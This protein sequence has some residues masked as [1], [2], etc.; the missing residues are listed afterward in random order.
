V[1]RSGYRVLGHERQYAPSAVVR[2]EQRGST[3]PFARGFFLVRTAAGFTSLADPY[4]CPLHFDRR[5]GTFRCT[6]GSGR[7]DRAGRR[8]AGRG[9]RGSVTLARYPTR[10][11]TYG[12]VLVGFGGDVPLRRVEH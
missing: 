11:T 8:L 4:E 1:T 3:G 6:S 2:Y 7:W 9:S 12:Y 10:V 5:T